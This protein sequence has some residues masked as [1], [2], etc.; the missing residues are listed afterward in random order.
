M[1]PTCGVR[2]VRG[3]SPASSA[4]STN[5]LCLIISSA[6]SAGCE[7]NLRAIFCG[8]CGMNAGDA[9][10]T[11]TKTGMAMVAKNRALVDGRKW[12]LDL[13]MTR[14][15]AVHLAALLSAL[16]GRDC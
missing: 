8:G 11:I 5:K 12:D 15:S 16:G 2:G 7:D 14:L 13:L 10:N 6:R 3:F 1:S 4:R 9:K